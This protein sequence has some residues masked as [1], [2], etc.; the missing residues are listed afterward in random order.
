MKHLQSRSAD[1]EDGTTTPPLP[2]LLL[3]KRLLLLP[4][5]LLL[6][7]IVGKLSVSETQSKIHKSVFVKRNKSLKL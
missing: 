7:P 4:L 6:P 5:L 3:R 1:D 2:P